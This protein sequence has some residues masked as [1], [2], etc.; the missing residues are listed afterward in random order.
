MFARAKA[1]WAA[2]PLACFGLF[3][4]DLRQVARSRCGL[5]RHMWTFNSRRSAGKSAPTRLRRGPHWWQCL[6]PA[7][8]TY[9][10]CGPRH[11]SR[12]IGD[13][14]CHYYRLSRI[15]TTLSRFRPEQPQIQRYRASG[16]PASPSPHRVITALHKGRVADALE[17]RRLCTR[18]YAKPQTKRPSLALRKPYDRQSS[19]TDC[20]GE[21]CPPLRPRRVA[22]P[23]ICCC[24]SMTGFS[25][26]VTA[27]LDLT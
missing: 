13:R 4:A 10:R 20:R 2:V 12:D 25:A 8:S 5:R 7:Y 23:A 16:R 27:S 3:T 18:L 21:L 19:G 26:I 11:G 22:N 14:S 17:L 9:Q 24:K 1:W 15:L 6:K